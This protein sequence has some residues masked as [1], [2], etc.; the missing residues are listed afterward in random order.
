MKTQSYLKNFSM[1]ALVTIIGILL[2]TACGTGSTESSVPPPEW[3]GEW[4]AEWET[5]PESYPDIED[6]EFYMNGKFFITEDSLTVLANG[7]PGCIFNVDT[8]SHTQLWRVSND[9]LFLQ[10]E[11]NTPG[12]TYQ[13]KAFSE[14]RIELQLMDDIFV[15]LT[16]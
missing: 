2:F 16:K 11:P 10:N 3:L 7:Y 14:S 8:L 9:T 13:I 1:K 5:L 6:M 4:K 12:M 15:T